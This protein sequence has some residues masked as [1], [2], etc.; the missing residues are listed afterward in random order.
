MCSKFFIWYI[1]SLQPDSFLLYPHLVVS[2]PFNL[3]YSVYF[4]EVFLTQF[5]SLLFKAHI[6]MIHSTQLSHLRAMTL[7]TYL[8]TVITFTYGCLCL[9]LQQ[10][11]S[12]KS[13]CF[14]FILLLNTRSCLKSLNHYWN[15][16]SY[17]ISCSCVNITSAFLWILIVGAWE[18][19]SSWND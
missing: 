17:L 9:L 1:N 2:F 3:I 18:L 10:I 15:I 14:L 8:L 13:D 16:L 12:L 19:L 11:S 6:K 7:C 4:I 5:L